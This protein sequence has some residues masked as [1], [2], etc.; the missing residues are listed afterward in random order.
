[1]S[2]LLIW[3]IVLAHHLL[4][5][6]PFVQRRLTNFSFTCLAKVFYF[7][8]IWIASFAK[9]VEVDIDDEVLRDDLVF[10]LSNVLGTKL[11]LAS[12]NVVTPLNECCIEHYSEHNLVREASVL[13]DDL[14]ITLQ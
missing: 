4:D 6:S 10:V 12:L 5:K 8:L 11:H 3:K 13:K 14:N 2:D 1:M 7:R 9:V